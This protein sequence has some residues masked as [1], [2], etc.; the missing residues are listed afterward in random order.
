MAFG[1]IRRRLKRLTPGQRAEIINAIPPCAWKVR[2]IIHLHKHLF[3]DY[4]SG[5]WVLGADTVVVIEGEV[6][7]KPDSPAHA[8]RMLTR[9]AGRDHRVVT[10][11]A[12]ARDGMLHQESS[13]VPPGNHRI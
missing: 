8:E 2:E 11:V 13:T 4:L 7:N 5:E 9:L 12:L 6:L 10:A 1:E 3:L